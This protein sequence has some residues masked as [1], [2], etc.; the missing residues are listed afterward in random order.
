[1]QYLNNKVTFL[2]NQMLNI[3]TINW[4]FCKTGY[5]KTAACYLVYI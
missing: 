2:S 5:K 4:L 1:M 3:N